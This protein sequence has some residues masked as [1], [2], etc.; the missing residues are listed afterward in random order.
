MITKLEPYRKYS[1]LKYYR[2]VSVNV[3]PSFFPFNFERRE[4]RFIMA[5]HL[6]V[7]SC[8]KS[9]PGIGKAGKIYKHGDFFNHLSVRHLPKWKHTL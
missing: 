3:V 4:R 7:K 8:S 6:H 5:M 9:K 1:I 2:N